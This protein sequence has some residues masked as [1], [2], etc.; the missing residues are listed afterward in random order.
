MGPKHAILMMIGITVLPSLPLITPV[1]YCL[2]P[3]VPAW[4]GSAIAV[5]VT[6]VRPSIADDR[7]RFRTLPIS[8]CGRDAGRGLDWPMVLPRRQSQGSAGEKRGNARS[9]GNVHLG[10]GRLVGRRAPSWTVADR[11]VAAGLTGDARAPRLLQA[12][13]SRTRGMTCVPYSWMLVMRDSC[14]SPPMPY[15]RSNRFA[16]SAVRFAAIFCATVSGDPT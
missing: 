15:F 3:T 14:A 12:R 5:Q 1:K 8:F 7:R 9:A 11:P 16:P 6:N 4:A 2:G 13:S 10:R